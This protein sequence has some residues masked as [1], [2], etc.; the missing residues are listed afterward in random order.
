MHQ[1]AFLTLRKWHEMRRVQLFVLC[2]SSWLGTWRVI[3]WFCSLVENIIGWVCIWQF[4]RRVSFCSETYFPVCLQWWIE[5]RHLDGEG[6]RVGDAPFWWRQAFPIRW[7]DW[8]VYRGRVLQKGQV[9]ARGCRWV[10]M[11]LEKPSKPG[12]RGWVFGEDEELMQIQMVFQVSKKVATLLTSLVEQ[13]P[14]RGLL[15]LV[16]L[17]WPFQPV[18]ETQWS[19]SKLFLDVNW[20]TSSKWQHFKEG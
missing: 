13:T 12:R 18:R 1:L 9:G 2:N 17:L 10:Q 6:E 11:C 3:W 8:L 20:Q 16:S 4:L 7:Q 5:R 19:G 14:W 15:G